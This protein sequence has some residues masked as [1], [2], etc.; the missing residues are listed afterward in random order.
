M[1]SKGKIGRNDP[2]PCGSVKKY[3]HC[4]LGKVDWNHVFPSKQDWISHLSIRGRN[5]YFA[6]RLAD[7]LELDTGKIQSPSD[8]KTRFTAGAV[9]KIHEAVL[10]VWPPQS[11]IKSILE[12][13]STDVSGLYIG[14][15]GIE[16]ISRG[17][18]RHS[19]YANKLL[20]VDPFVY[21]RSVRDEYNPI[22]EP[23]QYR[24]QTLK[25]VNFWFSLLPWIEAGIIE[26]IRTPADFDRRLKWESLERQEKK[27]Q[28][29]KELKDA[30]EISSQELKKRHMDKMTFQELILGAPDSYVEKLIRE[31]GLEKNGYTT[32]DFL[33]YIQSERE[34]HP[35]FLEPFGPNLKEP[36]L[37]IISTGT[38]YDIAQLT[39]SI[40]RSYLVTDLYVTWREIEIDRASHNAESRVWSPFAKALQESPLRFLNSLRLE[41]ALKLRNEGRLE[42]MRRFL[43]RVWK[44][45]RTEEPFDEANARMLAE[46][47]KEEIAQAK[48]EW[49]KIDQD[50]LK[51][52]GNELVAGILAAGPLIA[53]GYGNF[54]AAAAVVGGAT[55]LAASFL[56]RKQFPDRFPAAFFMKIENA[57]RSD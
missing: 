51:I 12:G 14:D 26:V 52:V 3:K 35:D 47:L 41:H 15:Y 9:K 33:Q 46:E 32:E 43:L 56:R 53:A 49:D 29:N 19:L 37:H 25:N 6:S 42:S 18:V 4:C 7:K 40:T 5:L 11:D 48:E 50:L 21:P 30:A 57:L 54:V 31:L 17:I 20:V 45:A 28:V 55:T 44:H 16:Y 34:R 36:Q 10:E 2:C 39:A 13:T 24:S 27:F 23:E 8:Y 22:V 1:G 38:S